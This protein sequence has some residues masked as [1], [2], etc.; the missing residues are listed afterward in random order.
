[1]LRLCYSNALKA[2]RFLSDKPALRIPLLGAERE[3]PDA[4]DVHEDN[5]LQIQ[6]PTDA[7]E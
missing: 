4:P 1:M 7:P 3:D 5:G 6:T 2:Y